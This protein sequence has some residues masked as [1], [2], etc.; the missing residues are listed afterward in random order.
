MAKNSA[1]EAELGT[2]HAKIAKV[3]VGVLDNYASA[4]KAFEELLAQGID[5]E[6]VL[7]M[8]EISPAMLSVIT[9]FLSDNS[10][11]AAPEDSKD[12]NELKEKLDTTRANRRA[13]R[14]VVDFP[15]VASASE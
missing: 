10:I 2:L 4:Q 9:K 3:M 12:A 6:S 15:K 8:P 11:T 7:A 1:A 13:G 14:N 5:A